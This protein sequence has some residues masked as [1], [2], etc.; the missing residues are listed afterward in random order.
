M[1]TK[2]KK[3]L[4][5]ADSANNLKSKDRVTTTWSFEVE[6]SGQR[7]RYIRSKNEK[8]INLPNIPK[9][10]RGAE[11]PRPH[12]TPTHNDLNTLL[13]FFAIVETATT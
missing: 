2:I 11:C 7:K 5:T 8:E 13:K 10:K 9:T 1:N 3:K 12:D 6:G 4:R